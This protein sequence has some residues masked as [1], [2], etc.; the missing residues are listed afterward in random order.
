MSHH[1]QREFVAQVARRYPKHF[2][3]AD[4]LEVGSLDVNG[5]VRQFFHGCNYLG[6]DLVA[7]KGVDRVCDL[8][9]VDGQ[10]DT[11]ISCECLEHDPRWSVTVEDM[12]S[13]VRSGGLL[14]VTCA[15]PGRAEHGTRKHPVA[16]MANDTDY[17][18]NIS[19]GELLDSIRHHPWS[20]LV[21]YFATGPKDTY[22]F[23]VRP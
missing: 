23:G 19:S 1:S 16:G 6:I 2:R 22:L 15:G 11:V 20:E 13:R 3:G 9:S 4:V 21:C 7:G 17:Y 12:V 18:R 14:V 5:S 8:E 10:F